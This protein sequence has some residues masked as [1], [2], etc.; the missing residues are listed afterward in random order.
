L[1]GNYIVSFNLTSSNSASEIAIVNASVTYNYPGI[2]KS[3]KSSF[4]IQESN[5]IAILEVIRETP[6]VIGN[7]RV[8]E[9]LL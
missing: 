9:F 6:K 1:P 4:T 7:N 8:F 2:Q 3:K 5:S